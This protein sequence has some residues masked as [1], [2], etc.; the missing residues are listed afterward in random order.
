MILMFFIY[1][2]FVSVS[3]LLYVIHDRFLIVFLL[4]FIVQEYQQGAWFMVCWWR[5]CSE[6]CWVVWEA[7]RN[8]KREGSKYPTLYMQ[9]FFPIKLHFKPWSCNSVLIWNLF[10]QLTCGICFEVYPRDRM[11]AAACG[12]PF[13]ST[14]WRG[15]LS[16]THDLKHAVTLCYLS[17]LWHCVYLLLSW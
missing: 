2:V 15:L 5:K 1:A 16:V 13:C 7:C 11:T 3:F 9:P 12:H 17:L 8:A 6:S 14:C 4:L 10:W